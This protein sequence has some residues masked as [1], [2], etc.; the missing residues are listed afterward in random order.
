MSE[1]K[2]GY[3]IKP[4]SIMLF[5]NDKK[6]KDTHPD[7]TGK[8]YDAEG[9][10]FFVSCWINQSAKG[11]SYLS[12]SLVNADEARAKWGKEKGNKNAK[13]PET[14]SVTKSGEAI[15]DDLPF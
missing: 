7:Y 11:N 1:K 10:E 14:K 9:T 6:E 13:L 5:E 15:D 12:G 3:E 8:M 4:N 2:K